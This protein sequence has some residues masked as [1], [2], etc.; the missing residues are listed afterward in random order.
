MD[1]YRFYE[2]KVG[3][4]VGHTLQPYRPQYPV[5]ISWVA[6]GAKVL[7]VG[8]GDGVLGEK[9]I[10]E[11]NCN[12]FGFDLDEIGVKE[13]RRKGLK[14][15]VWDADK[16]FPYKSKSFDVVVCNEVLEYVTRPNFVVVE[17]LRVGRKAIIEFPNFG[18]WFYRLQL[19]MGRFPSFAL[20]GH[21]WWETQM[22]RFPS[23]AD[24][25]Q[26]PAMKGVKVEKMAC[27]NWRNRRESFL[28]KFWPNFFG[29]SCVLEIK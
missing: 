24:F 13:A 1:R 7:D 29:R 17:I 6:R 21:Q 18:F 26:L 14:A 2:H 15:R 22:I 12:V 8:C 19:L 25:L 5:I 4:K 16:K 28:A 11:K 27:I 9:L 20:Y 23:L 3:Y 10:K